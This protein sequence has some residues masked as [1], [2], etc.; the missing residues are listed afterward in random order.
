MAIPGEAPDLFINIVVTLRDVE[1][2]ADP[3]GGVVQ[4]SWADLRH[5]AGAVDFLVF[6][7]VLV[8]VVGL[9]KEN[10]YL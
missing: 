5:V 3:H 8:I 7:P 4:V 2:T 10:R 1:R 9:G 6:C